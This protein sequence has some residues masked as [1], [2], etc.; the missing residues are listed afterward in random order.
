MKIE[1]KQ[2][3]DPGCEEAGSRWLMQEKHGNRRTNKWAE[4]KI[5]ACSGT[6]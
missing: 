5:S 6:A 2:H 1:S 4:R 3:E